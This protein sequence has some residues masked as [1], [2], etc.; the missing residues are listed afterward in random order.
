MAAAEDHVAHAARTQAA[1]NCLLRDHEG[2][3]HSEWIATACF[4]KAVH[5]VEAVFDAVSSHHSH[6]HDQRNDRLREDDR[7]LAI[8]SPFKQLFDLAQAARYLTVSHRGR[9]PT[10]TM[11]SFDSYLPPENIQ[12]KVVDR[13]LV[14][15][16]QECT[17]LL[18]DK[19][20]GLL[21][22]NGSV[23]EGDQGDQETG[24]D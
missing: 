19:A 18:G 3:P 9:R 8:A 13:L 24:E 4:Y 7:F 16:E 14:P 22:V 21:R 20:V 12:G 5:L 17:R 1:I 23:D 15:I 2:H 6:K 11:S 10:R